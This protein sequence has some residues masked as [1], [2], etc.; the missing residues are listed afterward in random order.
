MPGKVIAME[1]L[2]AAGLSSSLAGDER[3]NVAEF[4]ARRGISRQTFYKY[5]AR[6]VSEGL[7]G[8]QQRSRVPLTSPQRTP[9]EVEELIVALR[10]ELEELGTE[11]GPA[12]I[13]FHLGRRHHG[14]FKIPSEATI[15][16]I[17]DRR[18]FVVKTPQ[19]RP[20]SSF[21]RFE[22]SAPNELWQADTTDWVVATG[23]VKILTF[24]DDH[25]RVVTR[26]RVS[27]TV[28]TEVTW[29][30]FCEAT[31]QWGIPSGQLT[32]NGLNFSGKLR[33]IEVGF[34]INLRAA[35][36]KAI[37]SRPF[38]P[39]TC[40]KV[41]RFQQTMKKWLR[42]KQRRIGRPAADIAELQSWLDEFIEYYNH[43]R[44][45]R[46]IGRI[47]PIERWTATP[48]ATSH[49][50]L[51]ASPVTLKIDDR[52]VVR[53]RSWMIMLGVTH[54]HQHAQLLVDNSGH[55]DIYIGAILARRVHLDPAKHY[56][57]SRQPRD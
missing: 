17:L 10:K 7:A 57:G 1:T 8:L 42:N 25:S 47:P 37:T 24:L 49:T 44:P 12:T 56:L 38:H 28:T 45:H 16:R 41:E 27:L 30:T 43:Q 34:E 9:A 48:P 4:C 11:H 26:S 33:G 50:A 54:R 31:E 20:K 46:A 15:W 21:R 2:L 6:Y 14:E 23:G 36:V 53:Y 55:A 3:L 40:G 5:R 52:G 51:P 22:A 32:D 18:G 13:Q 19:K 35:G 29:E 39:Q